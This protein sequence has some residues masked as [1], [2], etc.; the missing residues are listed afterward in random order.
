MVIKFD[1]FFVF[2]F[3]GF[4]KIDSLLILFK[5]N[6]NLQP[7]SSFE[8]TSNTI[9][10]GFACTTNSAYMSTIDESATILQ[11]ITST[12]KKLKVSVY[13]DGYGNL[14]IVEYTYDVT[15]APGKLFKFNI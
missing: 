4:A 15:F 5:K 12:G 2:L 1:S 13:V 3:F 10:N 8:D 7:D 11:A 9:S 14:P 6:V